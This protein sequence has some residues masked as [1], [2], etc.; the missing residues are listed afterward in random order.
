MKEILI[1]L[2]LL[3]ISRFVAELL[4]VIVLVWIGGPY[5]DAFLGRS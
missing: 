2:L 1:K 3:T 5:L 4:L